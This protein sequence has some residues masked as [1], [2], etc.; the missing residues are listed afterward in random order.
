QLGDLV[1]RPAEQMRDVVHAGAA[2]ETRSTPSSLEMTARTLYLVQLPHHVG[3]QAYCARLRGQRTVDRVPDPPGRI[4]GEAKPALGL[5]PI[6]RVDQ[7]QIALLDQIEK[8]NAPVLEVAGDG[9]HEPQ[10][11]LDHLLTRIE[12]A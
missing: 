8:S 10:V 2:G 7:S 6:Q 9:D 1:G 5:E 3:G 4:G 12:V 11:V